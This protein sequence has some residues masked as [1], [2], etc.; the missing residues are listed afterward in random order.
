MVS[1][2]RLKTLILTGPTA[3][4]KTAVALELAQ[5]NGQFEIVNA[6]SL[7]VYRSMNI[8]TA[9]PS[10]EE[11]ARVPH[12]L[13]DIRE[14]HEAFT[15]GDFHREAW[16]AISEIEARG[17]RAL[18]VGGTG[19]YLKALLYGLWPAPKS[20]P[21]IRKRLEAVSNDDLYQRLEKIDETSALRIGKND[22]Y[23]LVRALEIHEASGI[24]PTELEAQS[25]QEPDPKFELWVLDR[26]NAELYARIKARTHAMLEGGLIEEVQALQKRYE[27]QPLPRAL[28]SVGYREVIAHLEG[29]TPPGR[30][31]APGLQGV[32]DEIELATRQLVKN[33][34]TWFRSEKS[35]IW[36][37][38]EED[39][40]KLRARWKSIYG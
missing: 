22:R 30:K 28:G 38:L 40:P 33:Q 34:R 7:L 25:P 3:T 18:V 26:S 36:F 32:R 8:G 29:R 37:Q 31:L 14:P 4:G 12:H 24:T 17:K 20:D 9:K 6:D 1:E 16:R 21:E 5:E 11:L 35:S 15:A 13:I 19:F 27:G 23:R 2:A 10:A 39:L